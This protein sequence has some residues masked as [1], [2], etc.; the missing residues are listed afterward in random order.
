MKRS[1]AVPII[2]SFDGPETDFSCAARFATTQPTQAL[3]L[4]N[5][6]WANEQAKVFAEFLKQHAGE[7]VE[8][9]VRLCLRRTTQRQPSD[10][11]VTRGVKLIES[12]QRD[13]KMG[14]DEAL[15]AYCLVALNLNE[16]IYVD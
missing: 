2:A 4:L 15:A 1:L 7:R 10:A 13:E 16:F 14:P 8:D 9:R 12:L 5:S 3:G 6:A 11:E